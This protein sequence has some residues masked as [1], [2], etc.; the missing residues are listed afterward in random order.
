MLWYKSSVNH[1]PFFQ[2][3]KD[4]YEVTSRHRIILISLCFSALSSLSLYQAPLNLPN[5]GSLAQGQCLGWHNPLQVSCRS[6]PSSSQNLH[7][8]IIFT[9]PTQIL[10]VTP[11]VCRR[12]VVRWHRLLTC[13][14]RKLWG[15]SAEKTPASGLLLET[16]LFSYYTAHA[17]YVIC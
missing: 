13:H 6:C 15:S 10:V 11:P 12:R 1:F 4:W 5:L 3:S 8:Y 16:G 2:L 7:G 17:L 14:P 9:T